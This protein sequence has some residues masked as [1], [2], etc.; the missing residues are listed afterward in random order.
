MASAMVFAVPAQAYLD[1]GSGSMLL[2]VII[3]AVAAGLLSIKMFWHS[4][5]YRFLT[6]IGRHPKPVPDEDGK[7]P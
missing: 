2:Q 4:L 5:K 1:P 7:K 3:G 6:L